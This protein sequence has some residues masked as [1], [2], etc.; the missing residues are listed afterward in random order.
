VVISLIEVWLGNSNRADWHIGH[1][2][3]GLN[4]ALTFGDILEEFASVFRT[5]CGIARQFTWPIVLSRKTIEGKCSSS[6]GAFVIVNSEGWI[7]TAWHIIELYQNMMNGVQVADA[8]ADQVASIN[9]DTS[10]DRRERSRR[11][12]KV[13]KLD[14]DHTHRCSA[15]WGRDGVKLSFCVGIAEADLALGKLEPFDSNW[16]S[17]YPIFKDPTKDFE[18]GVSLCKLGFPFHHIPPTWH[19]ATNSF[20]L[21]PGSVP[22][23]LFPIDGIFTRNIEV[24]IEGE[25]KPPYPVRMIETSTPGLKGQ[26]GG[27]IFDAQGTIWAIQSHTV[28]FPLGFDPPVPGSKRDEKEHQFLN[29][30]RGVHNATI[31]G[32]M[33]QHDVKFSV[34]AY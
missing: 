28:H 6:I 27:P 3:D 13:G 20:E 23:P 8:I 34:S 22:L 18:P 24:I 10:I 17:T 30:G 12:S 32:L 15:W 14:K 26:S 11:L 16:M 21:P 7:V 19:D 2:A 33:R 5:A 9:N 31:F 25:H 1:V 29:V 4:F